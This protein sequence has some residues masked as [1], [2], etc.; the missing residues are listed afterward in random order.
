MRFS[1]VEMQLWYH[2]VYADTCSSVA[3]GS[4]LAGYYTQVPYK[5][6]LYRQDTSTDVT[7][8]PQV[9]TSDVFLFSV[10]SQN[11]CKIDGF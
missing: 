1:V 11:G 2:H 8:R 10:T 5:S 7:R 9:Y 3:L 4:V 6:T